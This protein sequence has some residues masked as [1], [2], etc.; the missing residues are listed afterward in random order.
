VIPTANVHQPSIRAQ[1]TAHDVSIR[2]STITGADRRGWASHSVS[3]SWQTI[4]DPENA[5]TGTVA[6]RPPGSSRRSRPRL[7][8]NARRLE[9]RPW[10]PASAAELGVVDLIAQHD[11]EPDQQAPGQGHLRFGPAVVGRIRKAAP[12]PMS[13]S[14]P[15]GSR[16]IGFTRTGTTPSIRSADDRSSI[17]CLI[18]LRAL[19]P[20][21]GPTIRK[22]SG[23]GLALICAERT[24]Q[25]GR[26]QSSSAPRVLLSPGGEQREIERRRGVMQNYAERLRAGSARP[27]PVI[28]MSLARALARGVNCTGSCGRASSRT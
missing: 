18:V 25:A 27:S 12:S 24:R 15:S 14:P 19:T 13:N 23:F 20:C 16:P 7:H 26:F 1:T 9:A 10:G 8:G 3:R 28:R 21:A 11:V 17:Y 22:P 2:S 5:R 4:D 6:V